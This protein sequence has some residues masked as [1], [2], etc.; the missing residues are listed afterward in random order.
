MKGLVSR[1][2]WFVRKNASTILTCVGSVGVV[3]TAVLA[4]KATP[5]ALRQIEAAEE[6]KGEKL[7]VLETIAVTKTTYVPTAIA[8]AA[9]I[10]CIFGANVLNK[11]TQAS[12]MSAY[13]LLDQSFKDYK[14][15][16][17]DLYGDEANRD[18]R[19]SI[20]K[21][22]YSECN[23]KPSADTRLFYDF[24][25]DR[26]FESTM[27]HV[28]TAEYALNRKLMMSEYAYLN[29]WYEELG[30]DPVDGGYELG[31]SRGFNETAYWQEWVDFHHGEFVMDDGLEYCIITFVHDPSMD[32]VDYI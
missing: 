8:G 16:V 12:L 6:K 5:K 29:D 2:K 17:E 10:T 19:E 32:F 7:T 18:I 13:A 25:S 15:K 22:K 9:T 3:A 4:V 24:H 28:L 27:E 23:I 20:A 31:W 1:S 11:R 26:Y 30:I 21:E 14:K